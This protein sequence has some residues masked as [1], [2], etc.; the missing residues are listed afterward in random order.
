MV[1]MIVKNVLLLIIYRQYIN[2]TFRAK[3]NER[4]FLQPV[5]TQPKISCIIIQYEGATAIALYDVRFFMPNCSVLKLMLYISLYP[6]FVIIK[7]SLV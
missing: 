4:G 1:G 3:V 6:Q 7:Y 2:K 5:S